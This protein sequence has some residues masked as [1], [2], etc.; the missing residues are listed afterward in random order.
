[1]S[2]I[3][4]AKETANMAIRFIKSLPCFPCSYYD[5]IR[6]ECR[7][8]VKYKGTCR[9]YSYLRAEFSKLREKE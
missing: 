8:G 5:E 3:T 4:D 7:A 6:N 9:V 1:M 2:R